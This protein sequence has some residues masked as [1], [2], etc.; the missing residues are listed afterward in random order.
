MSESIGAR[1]A[2][3]PALRLW[4]VGVAAVYVVLTLTGVT[5]SSLAVP[6]LSETRGENAPGVARRAP[7]DHPDRRVEPRDALAPGPHVPR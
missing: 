6:Y 3:S 4:L 1:L 7:P 2:A 5:T